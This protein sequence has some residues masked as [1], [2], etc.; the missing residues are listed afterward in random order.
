MTAPGARLARL[1]RIRPSPAVLP[2]HADRDASTNDAA[3]AAVNAANRSLSKDGGLPPL[4]REFVVLRVGLGL[5]QKLFELG[6]V[7]CDA[8]AAR[9]GGLGR[10]GWVGRQSDTRRG[11]GGLMNGTAS[12]MVTC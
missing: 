12:K 11:A 4:L 9:F 7:V 3:A 6:D 5:A 10:I 1:N 2:A 8:L